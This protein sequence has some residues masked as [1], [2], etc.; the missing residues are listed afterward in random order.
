MFKAFPKTRH[1][2]IQSYLIASA[3]LTR[4]FEPDQAWR[5]HICQIHTA[6]RTV[7]QAIEGSQSLPLLGRK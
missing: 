2:W 5:A 3:L 4:I 1:T 7:T 6:L